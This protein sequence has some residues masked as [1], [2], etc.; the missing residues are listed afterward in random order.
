MVRRLAGAAA[1]VAAWMTLPLVSA[2]KDPSPVLELGYDGLLMAGE[3]VK[4][5]DSLY[6][7]SLGLILYMTEKH[8]L[9][10]RVR[11]NVQG[12]GWTDLSGK[13]GS[14]LVSGLKWSVGMGIGRG[15]HVLPFVEVGLGPQFLTIYRKGSKKVASWAWT[16]GLEGQLGFVIRIKKMFGL[17]IGA[18]FSSLS[19]YSRKEN[20]GGFWLTASLVMG[21]PGAGYEPPPYHEP[22]P[23]QPSHQPA[24]AGSF[25]FD[26]WTTDASGDGSRP[27]IHAQLYREGGFEG[28]VDVS[29]EVADGSVWE[30]NRE[31][32]ET[33]DLY[34]LPLY[35]LGLECGSHTV[36]VKG[37]SGWTERTYPVY[38]HLPCPVMP[39]GM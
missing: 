8:P 33:P 15:R 18:G 25:Y 17:R 28:H 27:V 37:K 4:F 20:L 22:P 26:A 35:I 19:F 30:L 29:L 39:E 36:V 12:A 6:G 11:A 2:A 32:L 3:D 9:M 38:V 34:T 5:E 7:G 21:I 31:G 13:K 10:M 14:R 23:P 1:L 24:Y 16:I